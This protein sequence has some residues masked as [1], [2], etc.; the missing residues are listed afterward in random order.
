MSVPILRPFLN[1]HSVYSLEDEH[2]QKRA[3]TWMGSHSPSEWLEWTANPHLTIGGSVSGQ[4]TLDTT[5]QWLSKSLTT[6][7]T[8]ERKTLFFRMLQN[9]Q[10]VLKKAQVAGRSN[11]SILFSLFLDFRFTN[12]PHSREKWPCASSRSALCIQ[13]QPKKGM[14]GFLRPKPLYVVNVT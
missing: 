7:A 3:K 13:T 10:F 1:F 5:L 9:V 2:T 14:K 4:V 8:L 12:V 6:L 11:Q